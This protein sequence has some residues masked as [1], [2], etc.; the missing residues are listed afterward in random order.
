MDPYLGLILPWS[1]NFAPKGWMFC[2]G[3]TINISQN[4][5]LFA[6]IGTTF[7]GNGTTTY[8]LPNLQQQILSGANTFNEVGKKT[9]ADTTTLT[10]D[11]IPAHN[12][13]FMASDLASTENLPTGNYLG[14]TTGFDNDYRDTGTLTSYAA[15]AI[16]TTGSAT[17]TPVSVRQPS[18]TIN[19]IICV[20]NGLFPS[21][22]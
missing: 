5:V 4:Q 7:G 6:L 16:G 9:G 1:G 19:F 21:R 15:N 8:N 2:Q 22:P 13:A 10:A 3:Q 18:L 20:S 12:H 14:K 17:P 11:N